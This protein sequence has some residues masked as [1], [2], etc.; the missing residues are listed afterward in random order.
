MKLTSSHHSAYCIIHVQG[1]AG[2]AASEDVTGDY[3]QSDTVRNQISRKRRRAV[4]CGK[5]I[6]GQSYIYY[7]RIL[8]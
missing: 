1:A 3:A 5:L 7:D 2:A 8:R 4:D 6:R